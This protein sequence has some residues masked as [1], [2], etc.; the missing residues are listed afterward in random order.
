MTHTDKWGQ[1]TEREATAYHEAA[2]AVIDTH[3]GLP[4]KSVDIRRES[5]DLGCCQSIPPPQAVEAEAESLLE[6]R[7]QGHPMD[8]ANITPAT[9]DWI[10]RTITSKL[11]GQV[12]EEKF[13]GRPLTGLEVLGID[14]DQTDV[15]KLVGVRWSETES[16]Q[17]LCEMKA[18]VAAL[19]ADPAIWR[20]VE[21]VAH[22]LL[23]REFLTGDQV[24]E[25]YQAAKSG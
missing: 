18:Q 25:F 21:V 1:S 10:D 2:H 11:A 23:E 19:V 9:R 7:A 3:L 13:R 6:A 16:D 12:A 17:R 20:A 14:D 8:P 24:N 5:G 15:R 4:P 22:E